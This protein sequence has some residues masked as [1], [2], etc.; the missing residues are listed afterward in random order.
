V[1]IVENSKSIVTSSLT[2]SLTHSLTTSRFR[3]LPLLIA[4]YV[5][6]VIPSHDMNGHINETAPPLVPIGEVKLVRTCEVW[7]PFVL[8]FCLVK[9]TVEISIRDEQWTCNGSFITWILVCVC[10]AIIPL[11]SLFVIVFLLTTCRC[12][13]RLVI[14]EGCLFGADLGRSCMHRLYCTQHV[15]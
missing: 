12:I 7:I 15:Q 14:S 9:C 2:L 10:L 1:I 4:A 13:L 6:P 5:L 3:S 11:L 8:H